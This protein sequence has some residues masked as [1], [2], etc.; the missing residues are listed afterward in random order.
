VNVVGHH[1]IRVDSNPGE[2]RLESQQRRSN[3][4]TGVIE[5]HAVFRYRAEKRLAILGTYRHMSA[6]WRSVIMTLISKTLAIWMLTH[7]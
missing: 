5:V 6:T 7:N 4:L 3:E 1:D 2:I